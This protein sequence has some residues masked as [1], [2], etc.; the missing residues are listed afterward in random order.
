MTKRITFGL[1]LVSLI[2]ISAGE[3]FTVS[4]PAWISSVQF[5]P[6]SKQLAVGCADSAAHILDAS[7]GEESVTFRGHE[8]YVAA[9]A[10]SPDGK[11]LATS[12]FDHTARLWDLHSK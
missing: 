3:R 8:D 6:D 1:L 5:S 4:L 7:S 11:I 2:S 10:F 12:S 9:V